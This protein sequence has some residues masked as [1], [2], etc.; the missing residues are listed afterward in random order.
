MINDLSFIWDICDIVKLTTLCN[1]WFLVH[2]PSLTQ[3]N[4]VYL[5]STCVDPDPHQDLTLV[6]WQHL[7]PVMYQAWVE[8]L[9]Q[10]WEWNVFSVGLRNVLQQPVA[11]LCVIPNTITLTPGV[12]LTALVSLQWIEKCQQQ[13]ASDIS[14]CVKT[15]YVSDTD[16]YDNHALHEVLVITSYS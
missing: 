10:A 12:C 9:Y 7:T 11:N 1:T 15:A 3:N 13:G 5:T 6:T 2:V 8:F 14:L 16:T 4:R